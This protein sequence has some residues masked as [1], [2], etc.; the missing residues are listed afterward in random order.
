M[1]ELK[2]VSYSHDAMIDMIIANPAISGG[3][4]AKEFGYTQTWI[5]IIVNSDAFKERLAERKGQ[6]IDPQITATIESRLEGLA[7]RSLDRLLER[8]ESQVP[9]KPMEL[10]AMAKLGAG[11]RADRPPAPPA[12][13]HL[14]VVNL[15]PAAPDSKTWLASSSARRPPGVSPVISNIGPGLT[16]VSGLEK[17][18]VRG[19]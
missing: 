6:L 12:S 1:G 8:V 15:P 7:R 10:V 18:E 16:V 13:N 2:K 4:L 9:L 14:Y 17:G 5:S 19:L 11:N 3:E